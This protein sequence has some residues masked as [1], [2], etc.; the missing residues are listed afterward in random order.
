MNEKKSFQLTIVCSYC[1]DDVSSQNNEF[2]ITFYFIK[3]NTYIYNN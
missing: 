2:K 1:F 3:Q